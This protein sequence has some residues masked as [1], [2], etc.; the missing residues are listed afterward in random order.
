MTLS[1]AL[2]LARSLRSQGTRCACAATWSRPDYASEPLGGRALLHR[3]FWLTSL[4]A[5]TGLVLGT[6]AWA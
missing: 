1:A 3:L 6:W 5:W 2:K 4:V